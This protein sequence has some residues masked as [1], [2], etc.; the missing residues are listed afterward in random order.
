MPDNGQPNSRSN[1]WSNSW[2]ALRDSDRD[3]ALCLLFNP[4]NSRPVLADRL[5]LALEAEISVRVTSEPMLAAIR[6]QWW[7]DAIESRRH[8]NVPLMRRL[9]MHLESGAIRQ[10]D[11][12]A[13][14]ALWQDRLAD[15]TISAAS[16]WR[17]V[18]VLLAGG[19]EPQPAAGRVGAALQDHELAAQLDE[20]I[21]AGLRT[22]QL[23]WI[24]MAGQLARHRLS[25]G[26]RDDDA[27]LVWRMLAWRLGIRRPS[28]VPIP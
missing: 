6:L 7:A 8:E 23:Y 2:Q 18:F 25:G 27:L 14:L 12:L 10:D 28:P 22:R 15:N 16:C 20:A 17:D 4:T 24:W 5:N 21:L 19:Q 1:D 11:L 3:L 9:L 13:Q 26:Y